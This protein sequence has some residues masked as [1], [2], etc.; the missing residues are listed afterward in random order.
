VPGYLIFVESQVPAKSRTLLKSCPGS[1]EFDRRDVAVIPQNTLTE[2]FCRWV[3]RQQ[4]GAERPVGQE[5]VY[6]SARLWIPSEND[7]Q[8]AA[9]QYAAEL[10]QRPALP[11]E[12]V[13]V[14]KDGRIRAQGAMGAMA[15]NGY[16]TRMIFERNKGSRTFYVAESYSLPWMFSHMEP[17][18]VIMRLRREPLEE[19]SAEVVA[20]DRAYWDALVTELQAD[21]KFGRDDL[22]RQTY[23]KLRAGSGGLYVWRKMTAEAEYAFRQALAL[24]PGS[25]DANFRLAQLYAE[26]DRFDDSLAVLEKYREMNPYDGVVTEVIRTVREA[27]SQGVDVLR[28]ERN[29]A[30]QPDDFRVAVDLARA[31]GR[32]RNVEALDR[33]VNRMLTGELS[34]VNFLLVVQVY[35]D[36]RDAERVLK[37]AQMMAQRHPQSG[38]AWY[39][40]GRAYG[41]RNDCANCIAAL[42]KALVFDSPDGQ[43]RGLIERD[44]RLNNC[45]TDPAFARLLFPM[46]R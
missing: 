26:S 19:L 45:R 20:K 23:A 2:P 38:M 37:V 13:R 6:P 22:A 17:H 29:F 43:I 28:L 15:M 18:G 10:R 32:R 24:A 31:Y 44:T 3:L 4:Y 41:I 30:A 42:E 25:P 5:S 8:K 16:L 21:E 46:S 14:D 36:L 39:T 35:A 9:Q 33:H 11:G 1:G 12:G 34:V 27:R 7:E 40:L